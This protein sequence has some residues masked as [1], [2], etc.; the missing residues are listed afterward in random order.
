[1]YWIFIIIFFWILFIL[2]INGN[3]LLKLQR[4]LHDRIDLTVEEL[5]KKPLNK[6]LKRVEICKTTTSVPPVGTPNWCLNEEALR[7]F[8]RSSN[9]TPTYD[10]DTDQDNENDEYYNNTENDKNDKH[11]NKKR[12]NKKKQK[13]KEKETKKKG[14]KHKS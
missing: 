12:K 2:F 1:M 8:N 11:E 9:E 7:K 6:K 10:C 13:K 14:K 3:Y 5:R 4:L